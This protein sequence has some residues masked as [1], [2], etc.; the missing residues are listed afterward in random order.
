MVRACQTPRQPLRTI[1]QGTLA[2]GWRRGRQRK[3]WVD[4]IKERTSLPIPELLTM[5]SCRRVWKRI[6]AQS[7][8]M[9]TRRHNWSRDWSELNWTVETRNRPATITVRRSHS[10]IISNQPQWTRKWGI[11]VFF[12]LLLLLS[13][14]CLFVFCLFLFCFCFCF[15]CFVLFCFVLCVFQRTYK[16]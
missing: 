3:C 2:G 13:F 14:V 12:C 7:F 1:L 10:F 6:S 5:A 16:Y 9:S 11:F 8:V 4:N 15:F